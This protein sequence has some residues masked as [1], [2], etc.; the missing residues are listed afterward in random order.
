MFDLIPIAYRNVNQLWA[1]ILTETLKRLGLTCAIICPGSRSTPLA[2]AF[3]QQAP[4]IETISILDERSAAFFALGQAKTTGRP[5]VLVC[6]SGTAG[7]NF[8]S[9]VIE[10]S[11][12]RVPL[13][14]LTTDRPP[15]LRDCHS[16]QTVDQL[17][18]Y[19]NYP[20]WQTELAL[21]CADLGMLAY[22]R[23]T[24]IHSWERAQTPTKGPVHLNIPFR[25]PLAPL[26]DGNDL[27]Y[28]RSQLE[29]ED[30]F[31]GIANPCPM[32]HTSTALSTS[33]PYPI[34]KEWKECDRGIIIAGVAQPSQPEEY[35][36]AIA[37]LSQILQWPVLAEGLSPVRNYAELNPYLIST[38]D[39]IL[40]NQQL[41][42][43]LAPE[44][45]IQVGEMP[46]SKELRTWIAATQP[47]RWV[48]DPSDQNLDPLH[49]RT[50]HLRI[51]VEEIKVEEA[52]LSLSSDYG[53]QWRDAETKV[54]LVVD[55]TMGKIDEIIE[56][57]AAWL[58]SQILPPGTPLFIANS[59]PV[60][61]VEYFWKPNNLGVRSHFNRGA[62][63]IDGTLSTALGIAHRQQSSVMLTG[64]LAL[65]HD[66]NGFLI[67]NKFVGHLTIVL[68]NNNGGGIFEM[69]P[70][71][72]FD[73]PFEEFFG[74]PQDINF[75]QLCATYNVQHELIISWQ[76]L[77]Q[78]L[79]PLPTQ[80]I[81]VL[82]V[83]TNRKKDAKWRQYNLRRFA[84]DIVI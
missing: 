10:A 51:S 18:L 72:K 80:G 39:L 13:L 16:G 68:I 33:S 49:G 8:Y 5:V 57:K 74:T 44:M 38:Y 50:T 24:V 28:L 32:P 62:N 46:T 34:P 66:T 14:I 21:P 58:I 77:Q 60:R 27:S 41:A 31:A 36:K 53:K 15:E 22:L 11:Y 59:M 20:N 47:R 75:V 67:R 29:A 12:S 48:I 17:R 45:V 26:P 52:N 43:Q 70:I 40:R 79:N 6:T 4:E 55:Q 7:A 73:P 84:A 1:Y 19:G 81:R 2:I 3:A 56:S 61:D 64:D 30:F 54:K 25:D 9:A 76:Q 42:K 23:Q 71:A 35:C 65:L 37:Q 83:Q 78:K 69:L 63:G 82:E